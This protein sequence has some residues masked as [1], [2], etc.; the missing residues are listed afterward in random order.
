MRLVLL[1]PP[2]AGKG[3]QAKRLAEALGILH[4][5]TGDMFRAAI[6]NGTPVGLQ[7]K[8][9]M[10]K[11]ELVPDE[12]VDALVA[13]RLQQPDANGG[14]ILDGYPRTIAQAGA[15]ARILADHQTP[16]D[17][18]VCIDVEQDELV[19]RILARGQ[20]RVDDSEEVVRN[21]LKV[22]E[23]QTAPLINHYGAQGKLRRV[24]GHGSIDDVFGH[25][26]ESVGGAA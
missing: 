1:G 10:D 19:K 11:G 8:G 3:T 18:V 21:R 23:E 20:G 14:Y 4:L 9:F 5:S 17:H 16:L 15:L 6:A 13:E 2:G 22:Y 26:R 12:V 25:V 24:D 7:A